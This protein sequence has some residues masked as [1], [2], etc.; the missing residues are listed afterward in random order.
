MN[1]NGISQLIKPV[2]GFVKKSAPLIKSY[3]G[4]ALKFISDHKFETGL[5]A[6]TGI[7]VADDIRVRK[8]RN[9][10]RE[11]NVLYQEAIKKHQAEINALK[12]D[13]EREA[14]KN[15]LWEELQARMEA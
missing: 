12:S 2:T 1:L 6:A 8:S 14:Y 9:Q 10:E 13:I 15:R 4:K 7:L 5:T 3:G 11:K